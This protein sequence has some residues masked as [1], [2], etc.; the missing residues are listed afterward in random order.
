MEELRGASFSGSASSVEAVR[1][2]T[3]GSGH[4]A[5]AIS[6]VWQGLR[7]EPVL[8]L[9]LEPCQNGPWSGWVAGALAVWQ[10]STAAGVGKN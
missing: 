8:E 10:H 6:T 2:F 5:A 9:L 4:E 1:G 3:C 7:V